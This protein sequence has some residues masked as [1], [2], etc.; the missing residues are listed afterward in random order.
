MSALTADGLTRR[1]GDLIAVNNLTFEVPDGV[2]AG[3]VGP[4]GSG[5]STTIRVLLGL[6]E[7][8]GGTG[9]VLGESIEQ[10]VAPIAQSFRP[11]REDA[12][13]RLLLGGFFV[14]EAP[15]RG[16]RQRIWLVSLRPDSQ[17]AR[18][19]TRMGAYMSTTCAAGTPLRPPRRRRHVRSGGSGSSRFYSLSQLR[20]ACRWRPAC[21]AA[22]RAGRSRNRHGGGLRD[23]ELRLRSSVRQLSLG[24]C[25]LP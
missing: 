23:G 6:I 19:Q 14:L 17:W 8:S 3:F 18:A 7:A 1:F 24:R 16:R 22:R 2:V 9:T 25:S 20:R 11:R 13:D 5:K 10:R 15:V 4:N 12:R 21:A